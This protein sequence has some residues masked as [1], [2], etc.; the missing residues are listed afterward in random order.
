MINERLVMENIKYSRAFKEQCVQ[1]K[2]IDLK[3]LLQ[4]VDGT[5]A[6]LTRGKQQKPLNNRQ[7][8][9]VEEEFKQLLNFVTLKV[10]DMFN[11]RVHAS[12]RLSQDAL[13]KDSVAVSDQGEK[14]ETG[15]VSD[16]DQKQSIAGH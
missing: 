14:S 1:K 12:I 7:R 15:A 4:H 10:K 6:I 5:K 3:E 8:D 16:Q 9:G 2:T 13:A 11:E